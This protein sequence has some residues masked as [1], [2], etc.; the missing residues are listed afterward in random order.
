MSEREWDNEWLRDVWWGKQM[1]DLETEKKLILRGVAL[2]KQEL[3]VYKHEL[4]QVARG[5]GDIGPDRAKWV[6]ERG[7]EF[8][9]RR[10]GSGTEETVSGASEAVG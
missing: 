3:E 10:V 6:L 7:E 1:T 2:M 5:I 8:G 4:E 9:R